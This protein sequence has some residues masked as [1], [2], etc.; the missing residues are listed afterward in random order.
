MYSYGSR[1]FT[2]DEIED[3]GKNH[4][5]TLTKYYPPTRW[6]KDDNEPCNLYR[7]DAEKAY[8]RGYANGLKSSYKGDQSHLM[9]NL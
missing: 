2:L 6:G 7:A 9:G 1:V 3:I 8:R 5:E 4:G